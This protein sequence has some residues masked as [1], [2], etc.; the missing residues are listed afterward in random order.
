MALRLHLKSKYV[1]A[2][3]KHFFISRYFLCR[4]FLFPNIFPI[5]P[6]ASNRS[7]LTTAADIAIQGWYRQLALRIELGF[8][9]LFFHWWKQIQVL[10]FKFLLSTSVLIVI[11]TDS[12]CRSLTRLERH[13]FRSIDS[14]VSGAVVSGR[15]SASVAG[16]IFTAT[17]TIASAAAELS[18]IPDSS[19]IF[20]NPP[21]ID[22]Q[23]QEA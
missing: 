10:R 16:L 13:G 19:T 9:A 8:G 14:I 6:L 18:A 2:S 15:F 17:G 3:R 22:N 4:S 12:R 1:F 5:T 11:C 23:L 20:A 7:R 21:A